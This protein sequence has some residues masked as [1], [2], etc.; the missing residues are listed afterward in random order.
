MVDLMACK[1]TFTFLERLNESGLLWSL[2]DFRISRGVIRGKA[3]QDFAER[4]CLV[5]TFN[6]EVPRADTF[7]LAVINNILRAVAQFLPA[8]LMPSQRLGKAS[9]ISSNAKKFQDGKWEF[10]WEQAL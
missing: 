7:L 1:G 10:L 6:T 8:L 3:R 2:R 4:M 9:H 5:L